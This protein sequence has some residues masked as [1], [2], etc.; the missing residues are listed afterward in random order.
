MKQQ[1]PTCG[2]LC[3]I[4]DHQLPK[5]YI[6]HKKNKMGLNGYLLES[7]DGYSKVKTTEGYIITLPD[8]KVKNGHL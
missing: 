8:E 3:D 5:V 6:K 1:C 4:Q 7:K 2:Q